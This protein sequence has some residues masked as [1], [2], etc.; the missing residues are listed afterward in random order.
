M[1]IDDLAALGQKMKIARKEKE[2]TQQELADLSHVWE[3][4]QAVYCHLLRLL[5]RRQRSTG[6]TDVRRMTFAG[7]FFISL[8]FSADFTI[9]AVLLHRL[10]SFSLRAYKLRTA[11]MM[12]FHSRSA[13]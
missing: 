8:I 3:I 13:A 6:F 9:M 11:P 7:K 12:M 10:D 2:L 4:Q 5:L 1:P